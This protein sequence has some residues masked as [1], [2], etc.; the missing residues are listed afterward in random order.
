[1]FRD[2]AQPMEAAM[3]SDPGFHSLNISRRR[4]LGV[5]TLVAGATLAAGAA[6]AGTKFSQA[7]VKYQPTAKNG[8]ACKTCTQ[9]QAPATCKVVEG[10]VSAD[11]WCLI[12]VH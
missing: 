11:G 2:D 12:Y 1:M 8:Q 3:T 6:S 4:L 9:F 7:S 10:K 5:A